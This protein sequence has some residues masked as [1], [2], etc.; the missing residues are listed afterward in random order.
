M[1]ITVKYWDWIWLQTCKWTCIVST[2]IITFI[3]KKKLCSWNHHEAQLTG[4]L[5]WTASTGCLKGQDNWCLHRALTTTFSRYWSWLVRRPGFLWF[6]YSGG[7]GFLFMLST[8][9]DMVGSA[10]KTGVCREMFWSYVWSAQHSLHILCLCHCEKESSLSTVIS[11]CSHEP[12]S[13]YSFNCCLISRQAWG[14]AAGYT[15]T[16]DLL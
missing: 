6:L 2:F 5:S 15:K 3:I 1:G 9:S 8:G 7:G 10:P 14:P 11:L 12:S 13:P 16:E 4:R